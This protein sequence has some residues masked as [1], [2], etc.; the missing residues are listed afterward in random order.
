MVGMYA[1]FNGVSS[2]EIPSTWF[3]GFLLKVIDEGWKWGSVEI[4][5]VR[6]SDWWLILMVESIMIMI[7]E[8]CERLGNWRERKATENNA[9]F[10]FFFFFVLS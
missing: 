7:V 9:S 2:D 10:F 3:M 5:G 1:Q 6:G 4:K 8:C